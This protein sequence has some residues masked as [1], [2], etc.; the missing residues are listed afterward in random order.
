[1]FFSNSDCSWIGKAKLVIEKANL[2]GTRQQVQARWILCL[3]KRGCRQIQQTLLGASSW[4]FAIWLHAQWRNYTFE[5]SANSAGRI[6]VSLR[7]ISRHP[8]FQHRQS[9]HSVKASTFIAASIDQ[10]SWFTTKLLYFAGDAFTAACAGMT[11]MTNIFEELYNSICCCCDKPEYIWI[12]SSDENVQLLKSH[13][14]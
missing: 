6:K 1:M 9:K 8:R 12:L 10:A 11:Q 14:L 7:Q 4:S 5:S 2:P 3:Y 13:Q